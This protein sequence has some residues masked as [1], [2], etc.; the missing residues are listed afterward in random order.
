M[1]ADAGRARGRPV[2]HESAAVVVG[3]DGLFEVGV[4]VH[5]VAG[6]AL[7]AV[8]ADELEEKRSCERPLGSRPSALDERI[9]PPQTCWC[10]MTEEATKLSA[11]ATCAFSP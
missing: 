11:T 4:E 7:S 6:S 1:A 5:G 10:A 8:E 3:P 2:A 9:D